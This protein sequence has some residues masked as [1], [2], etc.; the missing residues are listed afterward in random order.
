MTRHER[1]ASADDLASLA[2][3]ELRRRKATRISAHLA[4]CVQCSRL[5]ADLDQVPTILASAQYPPMPES[6][7]V[8]IEA[9]LSVESTQRLAAMPATEAG[10]RELPSRNRVR[11]A[12]PALRLPG[13][14]VPAT[15]LVAAAGALVILAGGGYA[16]A[17]RAGGSASPSSSAGSAAALAPAQ[18]MSMGPAVTYGNPGSQHAIHTVISGANF[19]PD[20]LTTFA[21]AAV[22]AAE[23]RGASAAQ[24]PA[25]GAV[26]SSPLS[27][28]AGSAPSPGITSQLAG[29]M[30]LISAG[31]TLL[32]V[33]IAKYEGKPATIIV[34]AA[35]G[36]LPAAVWAV[37][38]ACSAAN[39]DVL[40]YATLG[41]V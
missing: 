39:R 41:S 27:S 15:R 40:A 12:Q 10:R 4:G 35:S 29:C 33:D 3:G 2:V 30:D 23:A 21:V 36:A 11:T 16:L 31:R 37:G 24:P 32:L 38:S 5:S 25:S 14:S 26:P 6:F 18:Q 22:H 28:R 9:A 7:M 34:V 8:R 20:R 1:H 17:T 19:V 13:F